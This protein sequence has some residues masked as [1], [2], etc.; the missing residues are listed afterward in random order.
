MK[1]A[2]LDREIIATQFKLDKLIK[3]KADLKTLIGNG[4]GSLK[5]LGTVKFIPNIPPRGVR[6]PKKRKIYT[7]HN[8]AGIYKGLKT[9]EAIKKY[10]K[11]FGKKTASLEAIASYVY[12][13]PKT[14]KKNMR[15]AKRAAYYAM[16]SNKRIKFESPEFGIW[17]LVN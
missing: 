8:P 5:T 17:K 16:K 13:I 12:N 9:P 15:I 6:S 1:I 4:A 3:I 14:Q 7:H 2:E 10:F 11:A